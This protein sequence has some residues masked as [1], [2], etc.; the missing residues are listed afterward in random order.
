MPVQHCI[1]CSSFVVS[2]EIGKCDSSVFVLFKMVLAIRDPLHFHRN[3]GLVSIDFCKKSL[4]DLARPCIDSLDGFGS[5]AFVRVPC[6]LP[7]NTDRPH[8]R[9]PGVCP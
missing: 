5:I 3:L 8:P 7:A 9:M 4:W 6:P 1:D 2:F